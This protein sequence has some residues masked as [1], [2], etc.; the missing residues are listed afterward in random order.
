MPSKLALV[1]VSH[2]SEREPMSR[3]LDAVDVDADAGLEDPVAAVWCQPPRPS[4]ESKLA[5]RATWR[6]EGFLIVST[7]LNSALVMK[8]GAT[9]S[10]SR[11]DWVFSDAD[12][13]RHKSRDA[14]RTA[15]EDGQSFRSM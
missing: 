13:R 6:P 12:M 14:N 8:R 9:S 7:D 3:H 2:C 11:A 10:I 15:P 5:R 4:R 1:A